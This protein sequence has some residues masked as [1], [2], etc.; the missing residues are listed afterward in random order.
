[1]PAVHA[2][3]GQVTFVSPAFLTKQF[4]RDGEGQIVVAPAWWGPC[5]GWGHSGKEDPCG[6]QKLQNSKV[7][8]EGRALAGLKMSISVRYP[9]SLKGLYVFLFLY[10]LRQGLAL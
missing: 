9:K 2:Q 5:K 7:A 8:G 1:M 4:R 10:L 3:M 6:S